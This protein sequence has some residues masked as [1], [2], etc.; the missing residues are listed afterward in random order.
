MKALSP[1]A[2]KIGAGVSAALGCVLILWCVRV[3]ALSAAGRWLDVG[4]PPSPAEV[5]MVL[6]GEPET[7]GLAAAALVRAGYAK[8]AITSHERPLPEV[9]DGGALSNEEA[10]AR[11]FE[12]RGLARDLVSVLPG[13]SR[14][15][16]DDAEA[17]AGFMRREPAA[18]VIAVTND[19]HSRRARWVFRKALGAD[20]AR[21]RFATI[22]TDGVDAARWWR[23]EDGVIIYANEFLK[24]AFYLLRYGRGWIWIALAIAAIAAAYFARR[25]KRRETASDGAP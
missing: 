7:R 17:L 13:E 16:F 23:T 1:R 24:L 8:R 9:E 22:P 15:T 25:W 5:V 14:T 12:A 10:L 4:E 18:T 6:P 21:L 11:I 2:K 3:P 20:G 19:Y